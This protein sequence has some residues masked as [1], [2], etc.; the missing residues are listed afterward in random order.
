MK[1][2]QQS[3]NESLDDYDKF[4]RALKAT[5]KTFNFSD[6]WASQNAKTQKEFMKEFKLDKKKAADMW[7]SKAQEAFNKDMKNF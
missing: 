3:V 1:S 7:S 4:E 2:L 5:K 6:G